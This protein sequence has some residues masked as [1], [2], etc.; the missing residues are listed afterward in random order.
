VFN[1]PIGIVAALLGIEGA[2][3]FFAEYKPARFIFKYAPSMF[4]IYFLPMVANNVGLIPAKSEVYGVIREYCLPACL[5]LM[6]LSVDIRAIARLGAVALAVMLAGSLGIILGGPVVLA[7]FQRWLPADIW[8]G[9]GAL[10]ASWI[11]GSANM[12][13]VGAS[14]KT[15]PG[16]YSQMVVVDTICPYAWMGLLVFLSGYQAFYDRWNRSKGSFIAELTARAAAAEQKSHPLTLKHLAMMLGLAA[17][18]T[19]I[20][21][22]LAGVLPEVQNMVNVKAWAII[23]ATTLGIGLSFTPL[24]GLESYGASKAGYALLYLVLAAI[25]AQTNVA[26][27][28]NVPILIVAGFVWILWHA[29]F[30]VVAARLLRAPMALIA[31]ASQAN[32][33]GPA[34]AP[35]VAG[36]YQPG[37][38]PVGLLLAVLG[39]IIG[40]YLGIVCSS[41]CWR[42][43]Q[44]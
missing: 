14:N 43:S 44:W 13:A 33:G 26:D 30:L 27:L 7:I 19:L 22:R 9:F 23:L 21:L 2:I 11:G 42:V 1:D 12:L 20:S 15:P 37:L 16:I 5:I 32:I 34:S 41:L 25:G 38:A 18:G 10:S 28:G 29:G 8:R 4:W 24:R 17:A 36:V 35:V 40:T 31:A 6:L 39:N 3:L